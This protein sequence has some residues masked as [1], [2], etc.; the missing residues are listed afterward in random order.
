MKTDQILTSMCR[1]VYP[2]VSIAAALAAALCLAAPAIAQE[3]AAPL[4]SGSFQWP[5]YS[6]AGVVTNLGTGAFTQTGRLIQVTPVPEPGTRAQML[7]GLGV[8][9]VL[10]RRRGR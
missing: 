9:V 1:A 5:D 6:I 2:L 10:G 4:L 3:A 7:A 8:C